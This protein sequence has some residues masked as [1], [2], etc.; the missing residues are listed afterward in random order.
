MSLYTMLLVSHS[1]TLDVEIL[2]RQT[3]LFLSLGRYLYWWSISSEIIISPSSQWFII[4]CQT[5]CHYAESGVP[6]HEQD[7]NTQL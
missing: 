7:L 6:I 4:H 1:S 2:D 5:V 3:L